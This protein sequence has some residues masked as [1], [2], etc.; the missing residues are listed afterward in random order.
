MTNTWNNLGT[1]VSDCNSIDEVLAKANLDFTVTK[2]PIFTQSGLIIPDHEATVAEINGEPTVMGHVSSKYSV[3]QNSDAFD[4]LRG[5]EGISYDKAG[6]THTGLNYAIGH[7]NDIDVAGDMFT[8]YVIFQNGFNGRYSLKATICPL[9]IVCQNQFNYEFSHSTNTIT[10]LHSSNA[11]SRIKEAEILISNV[12]QY[13]NE[14]GLKANELAETKLSRTPQAIINSFF[15]L[16]KKGNETDRA[17]EKLE[18]SKSL[19]LDAYNCDDNQNFKG[20]VWGLANA[21]SDYA[22]HRPVKA[23]ANATENK[24]LTVTF[25]PRIMQNF[26]DYVMAT[27]A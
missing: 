16:A 14:F 22:T 5:V 4:L 26:Y 1:N 10:I 2:E 19:L 18:A 15:D 8:P 20:T 23:T 21:F 7:L 12:A 3:I 9:R 27:A 6:I 24:F 17:L 13:M 11:A 25:D